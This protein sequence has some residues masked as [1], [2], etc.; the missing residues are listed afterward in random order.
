MGVETFDDMQ[1]SRFSNCDRGSMCL[2]LLQ[3]STTGK[4]GVINLRLQHEVEDTLDIAVV[5]VCRQ[6]LQQD[7]ARH[8]IHGYVCEF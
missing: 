1:G 6:T 7:G 2:N 8:D 3:A 5:S 4:Q